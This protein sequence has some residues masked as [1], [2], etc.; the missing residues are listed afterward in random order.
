MTSYDDYLNFILFSKDDNKIEIWN[1]EKIS[2][3]HR[4]VCYGKTNHNNISEFSW[5]NMQLNCNSGLVTEL[6]IT[7]KRSL[8]MLPLSCTV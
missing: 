4:I 8:A 3:S 7:P 5:L 6:C 2:F 1:E